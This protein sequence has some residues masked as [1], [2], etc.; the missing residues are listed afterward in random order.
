MVFIYGLSKWEKQ[1]SI[2]GKPSL[3]IL[4]INV[5]EDGNQTLE[6]KLKRVGDELE[7]TFHT[8]SDEMR[9]TEANWEDN[10][11]FIC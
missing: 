10:P 1:G 5:R 6:N 7:P 3:F 8:T 4:R 11:R 2:Q 9:V